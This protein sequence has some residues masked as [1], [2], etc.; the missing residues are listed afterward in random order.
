MNRQNEYNLAD[1]SIMFSTSGLCGSPKSGTELHNIASCLNELSK[2]KYMK[3]FVWE[4][5]NR[6]K[7][8][9]V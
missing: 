7:I 1:L 3:A 5:E 2:H 6:S 9:L 4:K 8:I